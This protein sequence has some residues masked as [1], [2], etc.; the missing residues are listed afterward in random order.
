M[1][2]ELRFDGATAIVTGAG[3]GLGRAHAM[4][5]ARRGARV[6]IADSGRDSAG[7]ALA[8]L[9]AAEV[10]SVGADAIACVASVADA[11]DVER[12][13]ATAQSAYGSIDILV[14]NAG[15]A[16]PAP[17]R[18]VSL[19]DLYE[20]FAV[21]TIGTIAMTK[22]SWADLRS[23]SWGAVVNTTSGVGLFGLAGATGYAAAKMAVIGATKVMALEG[24][25]HGVR[26][27][28][29]APMARTAMA[30]EV[31]ADLTPSLDPELVSAVVAW[32][33]HPSC[34]LSGEVISA[35]GGR[36]ARVAIQVGQGVFVDGL[37][38]EDVD[39]CAP[40]FLSEETVDM[41]DALAEADLIRRLRT[42]AGLATPPPGSRSESSGAYGLG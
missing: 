13:V 34:P 21:H 3:R 36:V 17:L 41:T 30:G 9:T 1:A 16:R 7:A 2:Q 18:G 29:I 11:D 38:P 31:F 35:G 10:R 5:L 42:A 22:A 37:T 20:E 24:A 14:N 28:A 26:V 6:V 40:E 32:L 12:I 15:I 39:G 4:V 19:D 27:N 8:E 33:A 25:R 23:S